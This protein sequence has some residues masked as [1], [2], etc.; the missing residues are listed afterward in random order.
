MRYGKQGGINISPAIGPMWFAYNPDDL[1]LLA[2]YAAE[3]V[4]VIRAAVLALHHHYW[5]ETMQM[6]IHRHLL[7]C[8]HNSLSL[9]LS[10]SI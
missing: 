9:S 10:L 2:C 7:T 3:S 8:L 4:D 5:W 1:V 6:F